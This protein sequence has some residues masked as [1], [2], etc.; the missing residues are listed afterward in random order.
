MT[1]DAQR[2]HHRGGNGAQ[3]I[4]LQPYSQVADDLLHSSYWLVSGLDWHGDRAMAEAAVAIAPAM[5]TRAAQ[6]ARLI[7]GCADLYARKHS[8]QVVFFSDLTR[9]FTDAGTTWPEL[10]EV[11][12]AFVP[13][14]ITV[15]PGGVDRLNRWRSALPFL[16]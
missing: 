6:D 8:Q 5:I 12:V 16:Q 1:S 4:V 11:L 2:V 9:M 13:I 15:I 10:P 7:L 3:V 14:P